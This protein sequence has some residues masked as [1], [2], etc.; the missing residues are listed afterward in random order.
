M[1]VKEREVSPEVLAILSNAAI[2]GNVLVLPPGQLDRKVYE[3]VNAVLADLGGK[4]K[5]RVGHVFDSD[6]TQLVEDVLLSGRVAGLTLNGYYPTPPE[7]VQ[8]ACDLAEP[9]A[10]YS[11]LE[12]SAGTGNIADELRARGAEVTCVEL[13]PEHRDRLT[14]AGHRIIAEPDF[15]AWTP[16]LKYDRIVMNPPYDR[17]QDIAHVTKAYTHL[18]PGGKLVALMAAGLTFRQDRKATEFRALVERVGGGWWDNSPDAFK[19]AGTMVR[20]VTVF[21]PG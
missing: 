2:K 5:T 1:P 20:S 16:K 3:A 4:W 11:A 7:L 8:R 6:P 9:L 15:M 17:Q 10:G 19:S 18:R 13:M 12:P 14:A 21:L